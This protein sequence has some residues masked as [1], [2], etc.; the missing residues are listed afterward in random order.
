MPPIFTRTQPGE[1][2]PDGSQ[3]VIVGAWLARTGHRLRSEAAGF[4]RY[5]SASSCRLAAARSFRLASPMV[6]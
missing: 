5:S 2:V 6:G 4:G 3:S 1:S